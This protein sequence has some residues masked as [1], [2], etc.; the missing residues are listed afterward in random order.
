VRL[1]GDECRSAHGST[2]CADRDTNRNGYSHPDRDTNRNGHGHPDRD[3]NRYPN[4][5]GNTYPNTNPNKYTDT[6][7]NA[8]TIRRCNDGKCVS[9]QCA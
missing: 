6:N 5:N 3:T 1:V 4:A 7:G 8:N 2:V 9:I